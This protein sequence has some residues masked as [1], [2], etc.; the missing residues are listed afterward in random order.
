MDA[1]HAGHAAVTLGLMAVT[2]VT[3]L[4]LGQGAAE[5]PPAAPGS[6]PITAPATP[7]TWF[8]GG[9]A[10]GSL[11]FEGPDDDA[12]EPTVDAEALRE[13]VAGLES[14][15]VSLR[16]TI[17]RLRGDVRARTLDLARAESQAALFADRI[18][19][20]TRPAERSWSELAVPDGR[21]LSVEPGQAWIDVGTKDGLRRGLRLQAYDVVRG[22]PRVKALLEVVELHADRARCLALDEVSIVDPET[23]DRRTLPAPDAPILAGDPVRSPFFQ[24]GAAQDVVVLGQESRLGLARLLE[25]ITASGATVGDRIDITTDLVVV[26]DDAE[27]ACP[28]EVDRALRFGAPLLREVDMLERLGLGPVQER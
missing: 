16:A 22:R 11:V 5:A 28:E 15:A 4:T 27:G 18:A 9:R 23:G 10:G 13:Q 19:D 12:A 8:G 2:F 25:T 14:D 17:E 20:L 6:T 21:V 7:P 26:L 24:R 1:R 3:G